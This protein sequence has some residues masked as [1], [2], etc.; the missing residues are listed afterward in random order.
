MSVR[1][2][3]IS[4]RLHS[5]ICIV[6]KLRSDSELS[7]VPCATTTDSIRWKTRRHKL[8]A[9]VNFFRDMPTKD[10]TALTHSCEWNCIKFHIWRQ[11]QWNAEESSSFASQ[12]FVLI[13]MWANFR[14][15]VSSTIQCTRTTKYT[16]PLRV[17]LCQWPQNALYS[18]GWVSELIKLDRKR[19]SLWIISSE[20][21]VDTMRFIQ[22]SSSSSYHRDWFDSNGGERANRT[23]QMN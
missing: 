11:E 4:P 6:C 2:A 5:C 7:A 3:I 17:S 21:N 20:S 22:P 15:H 18:T 10:K 9:N 8:N 14:R 13:R 19:S 16:L 23:M 12:F 1:E